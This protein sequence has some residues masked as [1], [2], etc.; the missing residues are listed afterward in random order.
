[1]FLNSCILG[2]NLTRVKHLTNLEDTTMAHEIDMTT[3]RAAMAYIGETPWH[4]LGQQL[5]EGATIETWIKEAGLDWEA[6]EGLTLYYTGE[7]A[8]VFEGK[9]TIF[10]SDTNTPLSIVSEGFNV[11]QP[12]QIVEFF[13]DLTESHGFKLETAGSLFGGCK[14]WALAKIGESFKLNGK[15]EILPYLMLGTALDGSMA[16]IAQLT[17]VRVV[18]SNTLQMSIGISNKTPCIRINHR[19]VFKPEEVKFNLGLIEQTW[20]NFI[21]NSTKLA[22][23][24]IGYSEAIDIITGQMREDWVLEN[25]SRMSNEQMLKSSMQLRSIIDLFSGKGKGANLPTAAN[26]AWGLVNAVT[27]YCDHSI[28]LNTRTANGA[29]AAFE[30][31][32]FGDTAKFKVKVA[33]RLLELAA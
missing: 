12:K 13:R 23:T 21:E 31:S 30:R 11:V 27:E 9:K 22:N 4:G 24:T 33:N 1:M 17:T 6:K 15:D 10:R 16:T 5:T 25:G 3:G 18:C 14:I 7:E 28:K 8:H 2:L 20:E 26:T 29:N 32:Q 19:S